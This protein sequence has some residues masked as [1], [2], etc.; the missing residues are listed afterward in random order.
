MSRKDTDSAVS[1]TLPYLL[2]D[3][4]QTLARLS[5]TSRRRDL[6]LFSLV[7]RC[8]G[9]LQI[10]E[11]IAYVRSVFVDRGWLFFHSNVGAYDDMIDLLE[12]LLSEGRHI[13]TQTL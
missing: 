8:D 6:G 10:L 7:E 13:R 5:Y 11:V 2:E 4:E 12:E 3:L 9:C 1:A